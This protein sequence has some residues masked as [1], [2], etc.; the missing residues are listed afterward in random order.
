MVSFPL[1]PNDLKTV[2]EKK[3]RKFKIIFQSQNSRIKFLIVINL[4]RVLSNVAIDGSAG[5]GPD[6]NRWHSINEIDVANKIMK[7]NI[8]F[9]K[10]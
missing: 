10:V 4:T 5:H 7:R 1:Q 9:G 2:F 8:F 3:N 6:T